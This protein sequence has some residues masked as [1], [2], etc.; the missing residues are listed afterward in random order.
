MDNPIYKFKYLTEYIENNIHEV[1]TLETLEQESGLSRFQLSRL[2]IKLCG[3]SP[4]EYIRRRKLSKSIPELYDKR[5]ILDIAIDYGFEYEQ[6]YI[7]AFRSVFKVSPTQ[8]RKSRQEVTL[9]EPSKLNNIKIYSDGF[10]M[11]PEIRFLS[12]HEFTGEEKYYNYKDNNIYGQPL[13][14]GI[15]QHKRGRFTGICIPC[16]NG[17]FTHKYI[18]CHS[19]LKKNITTYALPKGKYA[20]FNYTGFH[21]LDKMHA[22]RLRTLMYI[23][24]NSW[25]FQN[26]YNWQEYFIEQ[27]NFELLKEDYLEIDIMIPILDSKY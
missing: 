14:D 8:L 4:I 5:K 23:V 18:S 26:K 16:G 13:L 2:F 27:V 25:A 10:L 6:S 3:Y 20:V 7:R 17:T 15:Q 19:E 9:T 1:I 21:D 22:H 12:D 11:N 24:I